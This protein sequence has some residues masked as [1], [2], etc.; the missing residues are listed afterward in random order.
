LRYGKN[1]FVLISVGDRHHFDG[2]PDPYPNLHFD[3][4]QDPDP[5]P[6]RHLNNAEPHADPIPSLTYVGK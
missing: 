5:Y 6:D 1:G 2:K 4:D 3:A